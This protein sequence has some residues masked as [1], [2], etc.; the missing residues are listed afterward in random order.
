MTRFCRIS[1]S[2]TFGLDIGGALYGPWMRYAILFSIAISQ[3]GFVT[4]YTIFVAENLQVSFFIGHHCRSITDFHRHLF[5]QSQIVRPTFP[6]HSLSSF[7]WS[8]FCHRLLSETSRNSVQLRLS[9]MLSSLL[10]WFISLQANF[11]PSVI[12]AWR[13]FRCSIREISHCSLGESR[14]RSILKC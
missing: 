12:R 7:S 1:T 4:A 3:I 8:S 10:A 13:R 6:S 9:L 14:L 5:W 2:L 11:P